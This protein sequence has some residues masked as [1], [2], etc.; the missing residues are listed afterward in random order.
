MSLTE[1]FTVLFG[2]VSDDYISGRL[3]CFFLRDDLVVYNFSDFFNCGKLIHL[4][5]PIILFNVL[6]FK[7][8]NNVVHF[9]FIEL[10]NFSFLALVKLLNRHYQ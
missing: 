4:S 6:V 10:E 1:D 3:V 7:V 9:F 5:V 8:N 2:S